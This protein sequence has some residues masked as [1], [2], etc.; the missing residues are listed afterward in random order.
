MSAAITPHDAWL[1]MEFFNRG[2]IRLI[3]ADDR[4]PQ[5]AAT[6][7]PSQLCN[8][9]RSIS[10]GCAVQAAGD[11]INRAYESQAPFA[12]KRFIVAAFTAVVTAAAALTAHAAAI[13]SVTNMNAVL[14]ENSIRPG[15]AS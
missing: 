13:M 12:L 11:R 9:R 3:Q 8:H 4:S 14:S 7:R 5:T 1:Y 15:F 10:S 6:P 2:D